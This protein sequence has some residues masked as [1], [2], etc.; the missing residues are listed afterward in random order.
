MMT[1][2]KTTK[3]S[4]SSRLSG[5]STSRSTKLSTKSTRTATKPS[6][7]RPAKA[8]PGARTLK[9]ISDKALLS[10]IRR[11]SDRER[12]TVLSILVHLVEIDHRR[13]YLPLGFSS[14]YK[15][16]TKH[17][18]YCETTALRRVNVARCIARFPRAHSALASGKVSLSNLSMVTRIM[19]SENASELL[20]RISGA[21][22]KE[23]ELLVS[24]RDP[25]SAIR[26]S[27]RPVHVRTVIEVPVPEVPASGD[28]REFTTTGGGKNLVTCEGS[29][30]A[31]ATESGCRPVAT[32]RRIVLQEKL[33][34][35]FG[36]DPEFLDKVEKVRS[37]L[38]TKYHREPE[39]DELFSIVMD[40]Y[41]ERH[42]PEGRI[43][44]KEKREQKK[45][46][47]TLKNVAK[48]GNG[49]GKTAK[50][51]DKARADKK[52]VSRYI[53]RRV[54]DEVHVRDKG[55]CT[56]VSPGGRR[57]AATGDLQIDHIVPFARGGDNSPSNLRLL[58]GKHNRLEAERAYGKKHMEKYV[59]KHG[60]QRVKEHRGLY[61]RQDGL[62]HTRNHGEQHIKEPGQRYVKELKG[63]YDAGLQLCAEDS[64]PDRQPTD[65]TMAN[66]RGLTQ[67]HL[68]L[69][70]YFGTEYFYCRH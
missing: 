45:A 56:Y 57:C 5:N 63:L 41:I 55:C 3:A 54:R 17:L 62:L 39:F 11:L 33:R 4:T 14:L 65:I 34:I 61:V 70:E 31:A 20:S 50:T 44:R 35:T 46:A 67:S 25:R 26:D 29:G 59:R 9:D 52:E 53:P 18:G 60:E 47:K 8:I 10:G 49:S 21:A 6:T 24:S 69:G 36:A 42:S 27:V 32:E 37:L 2:R 64:Q 15:F 48:K 58:C 66:C 1:M 12:E 40:E 22:K 30:P 38:S 68:F 19:N 23:V 28:G 16:C 13:L 7:S 43:R 51:S